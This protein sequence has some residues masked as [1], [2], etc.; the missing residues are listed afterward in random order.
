MRNQITS[1]LKLPIGTAA[2]GNIRRRDFYYVDK[3]AHIQKLFDDG[4]YYFLSRPRRFGKTLLVDTM[5]DLFEGNEELFRGLHIHDRWD[6]EVEYPVVRLSFGGSFNKPGLVESRIMSQLSRTEKFAGLESSTPAHTAPDRLWELVQDLYQHTGQQVV[7]LVDEYDRPI[8]DVI[9]DEAMARANRDYL[10]GVYSIIKDCARQLRFVFVTGVSMFSKVSLFSGLN[11]LKDISLDPQYATIC[12]Y[13]DDD[14]DTVFAPE[15]AGLDRNEIRRWYNGYNWL[16]ENQNRDKVYNPYDILELFNSK[17]FKPYWYKTGTPK[18]LFRKLLQAETSLHELERCI[19]TE[20][21]LSKLDVGEV[22]LE[23]LLFQTGYLTI[24]SEEQV[25]FKTLYTLDYPNNEVRQSLSDGLLGHLGQSGGESTEWGLKLCE[26]LRCNHFDQ[27]AEHL[28][29]HLS[30]IP[31]HW[32]N[33]IA[34]ARFEAWYA[35]LTY[36]LFQAVGVEVKAEEASSRGRSDLV[37]LYGGQVF[38]LEL[39][40]AT[41]EG[42]V[43]KKLNQALVQIRKRGYAD[44]YRHREEPIHHLAVVFGWKE[45]NRVAI[46]TESA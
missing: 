13:T 35:G 25:G 14:I 6:W 31:Y 42:Q 17:K 15:L 20:H 37:I 18:F 44:K 40:V 36:M 39:K 24:V 30:G 8:L 32:Q 23:A 46:K 43:E 29:S 9:E 21:E 16:G 27:F 33:S 38:V 3:T 7:I 26:L 2:F 12:G 1:Q 4:E 10:Q 45:L 28:H 22:G 41:R 19:I 5:Q 11:N 34:L